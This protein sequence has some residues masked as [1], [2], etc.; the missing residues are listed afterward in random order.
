MG[1]GSPPPPVSGGVLFPSKEVGRGGHR[2][3]QGRQGRGGR[4]SGHKPSPTPERHSSTGSQPAGGWGEDRAVVCF[5][6][7]KKRGFP[8]PRA[9][10]PGPPQGQMERPQLSCTTTGPHIFVGP[11]FHKPK[12]PGPSGRKLGVQASRGV[13]PPR[14]QRLAQVRH[15]DVLV[16]RLSGVRVREGK[17][18]RGEEEGDPDGP[19]GHN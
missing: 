6:G 8:E 19:G 13:R 16:H 11:T 17:R 2:R 4:D 14:P 5:R 12:G 18:K 3:S 15:D 1:V 9:S 10:G 7:G